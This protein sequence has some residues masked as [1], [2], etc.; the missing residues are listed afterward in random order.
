MYLFANLCAVQGWQWL[1]CVMEDFGH[2]VEDM[3]YMLMK[4]LFVEEL[5][6]SNINVMPG[7]RRLI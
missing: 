2:Y 5:V 7:S 3:R 4:D 1:E 6:L